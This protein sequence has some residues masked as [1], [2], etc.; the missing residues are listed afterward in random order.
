MEKLMKKKFR[1]N[2]IIIMRN[3]YIHIIYFHIKATSFKCI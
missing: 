1:F 3:C 2:R